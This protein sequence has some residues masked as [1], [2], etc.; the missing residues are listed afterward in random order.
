MIDV[1]D[2][3]QRRS[4]YRLVGTAVG[5]IFG[6]DYTGRYMDEMG[7]GHGVQLEPGVGCYLPLSVRILSLLSFSSCP[8]RTLTWLC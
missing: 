4:R 8:L 7:L 5:N 2:E 3:P 6:A 1:E